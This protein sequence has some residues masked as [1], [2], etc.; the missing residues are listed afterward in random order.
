M[1]NIKPKEVKPADVVNSIFG[2]NL[3]KIKGG[4]AYYDSVYMVDGGTAVYLTRI[5]FLPDGLF[6]SVRRQIS[7]ETTLIQMYEIH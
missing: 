1:I 6:K 5:D 7:W 3:F 4:R 2:T